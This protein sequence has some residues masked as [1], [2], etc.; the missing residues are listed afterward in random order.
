[1][2][3]AIWIDTET[4]GTDVKVNGI[5]QLAVLIEIDNEIV[6]EV[7][8]KMKP[9]GDAVAQ[10]AL[11]LQGITEDTLNSFP[12]AVSVIKEFKKTL[13]K[14]VNKYDKHDKFYPFGYWLH[15]DMD[16]LRATFTRLKDNYFGSWF[17]P[18]GVDVRSFVALAALRN[19]LKF[20]NF[21]LGT[22]CEMFNI[23][24]DAHDALSDIKATRTLYHT[25]RD[26]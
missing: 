12:S 17:Y 19:E 20:E 8:L 21:K 16:F 1:M 24:I 9:L 7:D 11:D 14:Y 23:E 22:V 2:G 4:T 3:K 6:E 15:F 10:E 13:S 25:L 5:W 26:F 18:V